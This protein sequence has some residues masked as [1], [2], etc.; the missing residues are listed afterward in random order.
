MM[1]A[2]VSREDK[3]RWTQEKDTQ[4]MRSA[5]LGGRLAVGNQGEGGV[6]DDSQ[7]LD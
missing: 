2:W 5:G 4:K 7:T 1:V 3:E 6:K